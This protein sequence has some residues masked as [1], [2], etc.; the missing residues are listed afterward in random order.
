MGISG[1]SIP[2][3]VVAFL[4]VIAY[5]SMI[6]QQVHYNRTISYP[7]SIVVVIVVLLVLLYLRL[8]C[9]YSLSQHT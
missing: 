9:T 5:V 7:L 2:L 1:F 8:F 4:A 3:V 6:F